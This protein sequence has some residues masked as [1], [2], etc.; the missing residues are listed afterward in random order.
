MNFASLLSDYLATVRTKTFDWETFNC[1][2]FVA[3]WIRFVTGRDIM[4]GLPDTE[5]RFAAYRLISSIGGDLIGVWTKWMTSEPVPPTLAQIGDPV[6]LT[7]GQMQSIGIC[8]GR[9]AIGLTQD[10]L[11]Y[12][13][14]SMAIHAW[15]LSNEAC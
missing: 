6:L 1:C 8:C 5:N 3:G 2:Q 14:M 10:G 15:R 7:E 13:P 9:T 12:V 4:A 11:I